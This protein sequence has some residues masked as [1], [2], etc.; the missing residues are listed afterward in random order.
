MKIL[1]VALGSRGDVQPFLALGVGLRK[2][3]HTVTLAAPYNYRE[4][5]EEHG[6]NF[7]PARFNP[8]EMLQRP[9][10][11]AIIKSRNVARQMRVLTQTIEPGLIQSFDDFWEAGQTTDFVVQTGTG[12]GG[13]EISQQRGIPMAIAF[14]QPFAVTSAFPS[15]FLPLRRSWGGWYNRLTHHLLFAAIWPS[16][17]PPA[18]QWRKTRF[19]LPPFKA[20]PEFFTHAR[21]TGAPILCGYSPSALPKPADWEANLHVTGY[22]FL[23]APPAWQPA[24]ELVRF[25]E[26]GPPPVYIGFGSMRDDNPER[27][28]RLALRALELSGQRGVLLGGWGGLAQSALPTTVFFVESVPHAWLFPRMAA[29]LALRARVC[30]RAC[31][32]SS[33]PL[34][35]T[36]PVG[37]SV[38]YNSALARVCRAFKASPPK[39]WRRLF[40]PQ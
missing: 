11:Q 17:G 10:V 19:N 25:L 39:N 15:F 34:P 9:E 18:N 21:Q 16:M 4:W 30:G 2:A 22:W 3:G 5:V 13:T 31:P 36:K 32:A 35:V 12:F 24:P 8:H 27:L 14:L 28:T 6:I 40:R 7:H 26:S 33:R 23:E 1:I 37:R 38:W 29:V 20:L